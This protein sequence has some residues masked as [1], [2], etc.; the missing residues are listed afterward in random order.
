ML[1][2]RFRLDGEETR[3]DINRS[4]VVAA[5]ILVLI[6]RLLK[7]GFYSSQW[8]QVLNT[9]SHC[10]GETT[11]M[12]SLHNHHTSTEKKSNT[13]K[14][15]RLH[16]SVWRRLL[17]SGRGSWRTCSANRRPPLAELWPLWASVW[18][19]TA[20]RLGWAGVGG[21][22]VKQT[23]GCVWVGRLPILRFISD[24]W[25]HASCAT[26]AGLY[27]EAASGGERQRP[28]RV[29]DSRCECR[30]VPW[31]TWTGANRLSKLAE[32]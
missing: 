29:S 1:C 11:R 16:L 21:G 4:E 22:G 2:V 32:D 28:W 14:F 10:P 7:G 12:L 30:V 31:C 5:N 8:M 3:E 24:V 19:D 25:R 20:G 6:I 15:K 9:V 27:S 26:Q 13:H 17:N 18:V 23:G